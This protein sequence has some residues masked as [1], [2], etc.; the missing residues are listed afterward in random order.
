[1]S[2]KPSMAGAAKAQKSARKVTKKARDSAVKKPPSARSVN[3]AIRDA[4]ALAADI[5]T[6]GVVV[7][8]VFPQVRAA[9]ERIGAE[10]V[11]ILSLVPA[12]DPRLARRIALV[13]VRFQRV[14][15]IAAEQLKEAKGDLP[16]ADDDLL[17]G[18]ADAITRSGDAEFE[19]VAESAFLRL[20]LQATTG[21]VKTTIGKP[22]RM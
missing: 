16:A 14:M 12:D 19:R 7:D 11:R 4:V 9:A 6:I 3:K 5:L 20:R 18:L 15:G 13:P 2:K 17:I 1:M 8:A 21:Q 10:V 22:P